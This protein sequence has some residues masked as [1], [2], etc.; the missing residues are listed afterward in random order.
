M[1]I[2][3]QRIRLQYTPGVPSPK[4]GI[5]YSSHALIEGMIF[6]EFQFDPTLVL[7][8]VPF[9]R[10]KGV[11]PAIP[12]KKNTGGYCSSFG[13]ATPNTGKVSLAGKCIMLRV[14][15][16]MMYVVLDKSE[17]S[18]SSHFCHWLVR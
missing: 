17:V 5:G 10:S 6:E 16:S 8:K 3:F 2:G 4:F 11:D 13:I 14:F 1:V 9:K 15:M 18:I 12:A 7:E